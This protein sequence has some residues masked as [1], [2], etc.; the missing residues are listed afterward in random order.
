MLRARGTFIPHH[1]PGWQRNESGTLNEA[2][3]T[4]VFTVCLFKYLFKK[5]ASL[6][7]SPD[8]NNWTA[9][10]AVSEG[11]LTFTLWVT[12]MAE[13]KFTQS[14]VRIQTPLKNSISRWSTVQGDTNTLFESIDFIAGTW[15][16]QK[17]VVS[18]GTGLSKKKLYSNV[19]GG[20]AC[21]AVA[22]KASSPLISQIGVVHITTGAGITLFNPP[23][24]PP[25]NP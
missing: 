18:C 3:R 16:T 23:Q 11:R 21:R 15:S 22:V 8:F 13:R 2:K 17:P 12:W 14:P 19:S 10:S 20:E 7:A 25:S 4:V 9:V 24:I 6:K 5:G 1:P